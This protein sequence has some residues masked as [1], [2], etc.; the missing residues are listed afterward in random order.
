MTPVRAG[1][2]GALLLIAAFV[3]DM[4]LG[5][6]L[7]IGAVRP[8]V[9][10]AALVPL[11]MAVRSGPAAG[12]GLM[13]GLL[14]GSFVSLSLG[15]LAVSRTL[16]GWAAGLLEQRLFRDNL[17]V[18]MAA[19]VMAS[20]IADGVFFLLAPQ[21]LVAQ[22]AS[23]GLGRAV[24]AGFLVVPFALAMRKLYPATHL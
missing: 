23:V 14:E 11:A 22:Y 19:G 20:L 7:T 8:D 9:T 15:S 16:A 18:T 6:R 17:V 2:L 24:Y 13:A 10:L 21:P 4:S 12:L 3:L 1:V 5:S